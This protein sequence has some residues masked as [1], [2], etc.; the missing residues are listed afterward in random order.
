MVLSRPSSKS[1]YAKPF[2]SD[3]EDTS[4]TYKSRN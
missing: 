2:A 4:T 3:P 1:K